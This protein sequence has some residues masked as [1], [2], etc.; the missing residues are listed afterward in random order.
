MT[1]DDR[2]QSDIDDFWHDYL[3]NGDSFE[4]R[5]RQVF[6][7]IPARASMQALCGAIQWPGRARHEGHR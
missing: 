5:L 6:R 7:H 3:T 2:R 4:R 1:S